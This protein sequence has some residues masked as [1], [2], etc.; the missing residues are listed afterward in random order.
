[1]KAY[2]RERYCGPEGLELRELEVPKPLQAGVLVNEASGG[3]GTFAAQVAKALG[4]LMTAVWSTRNLEQA[5]T[6][7]P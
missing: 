4:A 7:S 5:R 1:M 6:A 2:V 3:V